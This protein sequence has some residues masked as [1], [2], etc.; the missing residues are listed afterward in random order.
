MYSFE[1]FINFLH[2][3]D[4]KLLAPTQVSYIEDLNGNP[5]IDFVGRFENFENDWN[6]VCKQL[7]IKKKLPHLNKSEHKNYRIY[8]NEELIEKVEELYKEDIEFFNYNFWR[9]IIFGGSRR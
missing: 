1:N 8:Y 4:K 2:L 6:K 3:E 9:N 5:R 7:G